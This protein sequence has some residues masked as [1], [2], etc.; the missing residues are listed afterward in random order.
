[1]KQ[2]YQ[3]SCQSQCTS[4]ETEIRNQ[5]SRAYAIFK[6]RGKVDFIVQDKISKTWKWKKAHVWGGGWALAA[7]LF[8]IK[9][10]D[11]EHKIGQQIKGYIIR[12]DSRLKGI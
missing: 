12:L 5:V 2:K 3:I 4:G 7:N 9:A 6:I 11:I 8:G 10:K 1:M